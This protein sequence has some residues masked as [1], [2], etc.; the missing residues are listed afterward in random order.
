M[1]RSTVRHRPARYALRAGLAVV[2]ATGALGGCSS[3]PAAPPP[4]PRSSS[5][6]AP[7]TSTGSSSG[8]VVLDERARGTTVRVP[9]GT[10]VVVRLHSTYW[11]TP[12]GSDPRVLAPAG[13]G[14]T[15]TGTCRP[16][17]GCGVSSAE[18]TAR[19]SGTALVTARRDSCGEAMRCPPGRGR[20]EVTVTVA[21]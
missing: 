13:A 11:S 8:P 2:A 16:G 19:R 15:P 10:R 21:P 1:P 20:Y 4:F 12:A 5:R 6:P 17:G 3:A 18:F 14:T 7:A 9:T